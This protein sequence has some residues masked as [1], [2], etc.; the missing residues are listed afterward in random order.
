M[1]ALRAVA[2]GGSCCPSQ[3]GARRARV[4]CLEVLLGLGGAPLRFSHSRVLVPAGI[5]GHF[6]EVFV[7]GMVEYRRGVECRGKVGSKKL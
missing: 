7:A 4:R 2:W 1:H 5:V 6:L 3:D